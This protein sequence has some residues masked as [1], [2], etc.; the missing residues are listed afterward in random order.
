MQVKDFEIVI[1]NLINFAP[2]FIILD[3]LKV[4]IAKLFCNLL[5][6]TQVKLP[7]SSEIPGGSIKKFLRLAI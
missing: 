4:G 7:K 2:W 3:E 5:L 1:L 6:D